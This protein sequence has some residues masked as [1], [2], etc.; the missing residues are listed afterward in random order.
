MPKQKELELTTQVVRPADSIFAD[1]GGEIVMMNLET[2]S[3]YGLD[4]VGSRV[5]ELLAEPTTAAEI[6][7]KL[8]EEYDVDEETSQRDVMALLQDLVDEKL[9]QTVQ[10]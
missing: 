2:S 6:A 7:A 5:W 3:Y 10:V 4:P 8:Q 9:V 1:S